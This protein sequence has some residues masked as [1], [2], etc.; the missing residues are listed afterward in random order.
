MGAAC[1]WVFFKDSPGN[2]DV[3]P[4]LRAMDLEEMKILFYAKQFAHILCPKHEMTLGN[5]YSSGSM[6]PLVLKRCED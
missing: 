4:G 2:A 3:Q 5:A 6:L 1:V